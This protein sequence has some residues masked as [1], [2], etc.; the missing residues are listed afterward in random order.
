MKWAWTVLSGAEV[1]QAELY[2][3]RELRQSSY[4]TSNTN[5][6]SDCGELKHNLH[7][8]QEM[9]SSNISVFIW[10]LPVGKVNFQTKAYFHP[11]RGALQ[12]NKTKTVSMDPKQPVFFHVRCVHTY[13][14]DGV[15][16]G[17]PAQHR[18]SGVLLVGIHLQTY[19]VGWHTEGVDHLTDATWKWIP[20]RQSMCGR[21][22]SR[23]K[24]TNSLVGLCH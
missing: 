5:T 3:V 7:R 4:N 1:Q 15:G 21:S 23:T 8:N 14:L 20:E 11:S 10:V 17:G 24:Q 13:T 16:A 6:L 12:T 22:S 18:D 9:F 19:L 2:L